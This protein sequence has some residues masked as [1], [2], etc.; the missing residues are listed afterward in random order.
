MLAATCVVLFAA[1]YFAAARTSI[2]QRIDDAALRDRTSDR[3]IQLASD[4]ILD[5][6]SMSSL[7]LATSALVFIAVVRARPR[8]AVCVGLFIVGANVTTQLAKSSSIL[9]RPTLLD[10]LSSLGSTPSFPSGHATVAMSV[11]LGLLL[12]STPRFRKAAG[13]VGV[14]YA[15]LIGAATITGGWH[16]PSEVVGGYLVA[17]AWAAAIAAIVVALRGTGRAPGLRQPWRIPAGA[18]S[19]RLMAAGAILLVGA[20]LLAV[21]IA[22]ATKPRFEAVDFGAA[23]VGALIGLAGSA[24]LL[25]AALLA[26]LKGSYLDPPRGDSGIMSSAEDGPFPSSS[27]SAIASPASGRRATS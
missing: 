1:L 24:V 13:T 11:A 20:A 21:G 8:L 2:G 19:P 9:I 3:S 10:S 25:L 12:V 6:I 17:T 23:Y 16:R 22:L 15:I 4:Q 18:T 5:T 26:A 27:T 14:V 7:A